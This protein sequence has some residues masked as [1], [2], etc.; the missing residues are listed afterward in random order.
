MATVKIS[1]LNSIALADSLVLPAS[2]GSTTGKVTAAQLRNSVD[3][4]AAGTLPSAGGVFQ[5]PFVPLL[6]NAGNFTQYKILKLILKNVGFTAANTRIGISNYANDTNGSCISHNN[7]SAATG[8]WVHCTIDLIGGTLMSASE[9]NSTIQDAGGSYIFMKSH[10]YTPASK[11]II[12]FTSAENN[13][14]D[15]GNY[16]LLGIR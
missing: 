9:N 3:T 5:F 15:G 1:Q 2:D 12:I 4:I 14:F 6:Q 16:V 11:D 8:I 13:Y 10:N 7:S